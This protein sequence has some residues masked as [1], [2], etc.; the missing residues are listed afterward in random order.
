M[1]SR[2]ASLAQAFACSVLTFLAATVLLV[3]EMALLI[4]LV[5]ILM[6]ITFSLMWTFGVIPVLGASAASA[7]LLLTWRIV[8]RR[9]SPP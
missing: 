7:A 9:E 1:V 4:V 6:P 3:A 5:R 8:R 2:F